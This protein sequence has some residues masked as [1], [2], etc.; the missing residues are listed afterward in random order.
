MCKFAKVLLKYATPKN[1]ALQPIYTTQLVSDI[2]LL[3]VW[4]ISI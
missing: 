2:M 1:I 3:K 4:L